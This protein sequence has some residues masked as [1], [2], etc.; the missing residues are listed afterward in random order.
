MTWLPKHLLHMSP[1]HQEPW[2]WPHKIVWSFFFY[3]YGW[4]FFSVRKDLGHLW[5]HSVSR[6]DRKCKNICMLPQRNSATKHRKIISVDWIKWN[7]K[8]SYTFFKWKQYTMHNYDMKHMFDMPP[9]LLRKFH[10]KI[11]VSKQTFSNLAFDWLA[12]QLPANQKPC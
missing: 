10:V 4:A 2:Y 1:G 8:L 6:Y 7:T 3:F 12:A 5:H 9:G 11:H